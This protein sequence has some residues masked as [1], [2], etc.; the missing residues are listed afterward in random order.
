MV[1][2]FIYV[3]VVAFV[4]A[5]FYG[6]RVSREIHKE[7]AEKFLQGQKRHGNAYVAGVYQLNKF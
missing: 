3:A 2:L 6:S 5:I 7:A 4:A 1:V